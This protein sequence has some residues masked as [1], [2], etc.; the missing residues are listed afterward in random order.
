MANEIKVTAGSVIWNGWTPG[1]VSLPLYLLRNVRK[2]LEIPEVRRSSSSVQGDH[3]VYDAL[4][5]YEPR[6]LPFEGTI[7][8]SSQTERR[9]MEKAI[10]SAVTLP[11]VQGYATNDGYITLLFTTEDLLNLQCNAKLDSEV[12]F[13]IVDEADPDMREFKFDMIADDPRLFSQTLNTETGVESVIGG[14]VH[15]ENTLPIHIENTSPVHVLGRSVSV[16]C[17]NVG[18]FGASPI[19]KVTGPTNGP[20]VTNETTGIKIDLN[21]LVLAAGEYVTIDVSAAPKT[22]LKNDGTDQSGYMTADSDWIYLNP[23]SNNITLLDDTPA[24]LDATLQVQ[25]RDTYISA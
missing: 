23:G 5:F 18:N 25:W 19:I 7:I 12:S 14:V 8:G 15:I 10:E 20:I 17:N 13:K 1:S 9:T 11:A 4:S 6:E 24:A 2:M 22:I 16:T 3:G 21:G